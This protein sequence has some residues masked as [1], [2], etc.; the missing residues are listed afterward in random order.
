MVRDVFSSKRCTG[1]CE[2]ILKLLLLLLYG[3][4]NIASCLFLADRLKC[5]LTNVGLE[6]RVFHDLHTHLSRI[7]DLTGRNDKTSVISS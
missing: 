4:E 2:T 6:I 1:T 3:L 7:R 5:S